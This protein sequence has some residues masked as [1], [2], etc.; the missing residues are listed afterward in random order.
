MEVKQINEFVNMALEETL[1]KSVI[2]NEDL[3]NLVSIGSE[4]INSKKVS[5]YIQNLVN[6]IGK[7]IF[8]SRV[9]EG[10]NLNIM[11]DSWEYG[12][13]VEKIRMEIPKAQPNESWE[14]K[15]GASYDTNIFYSPKIKVKFWND[16]DTFEV[17]ISITYKQL[18][19]SFSNAQQYNSF[20]SMIFTM[21]KNGMIVHLNNLERR[22]INNMIGLT[23]LSD[24]T[25]GEYS[26]KSGVKAI[27]LLYLYNK[28]KV[29]NERL[30]KETALTNPNFLRF[31][32]QVIYL[33]MD[34][35]REYSTLY[36]IE[37]CENFTKKEDMHVVLLSDFVSS[38]VA[39][40]QSD[41]YHKELVSL[42]LYEKINYWQGSGIGYTFS[43][44]SKIDVKTS[45]NTTL[46]L[47][48]IVGVLFDKDALGISNLDER[49]TDN[50]NGKA[51]FYT[52]WHKLDAGFWNDPCENFVVFFM[53]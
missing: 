30:T 10:L 5:A 36:N 28:D 20:N 12:S 19:M 8:V 37:G 21:V 35:L 13:I 40:L 32:T 17:P 29:E 18:K 42:P 9:Y 4:L 52:Y 24:Y 7:V 15:D 46:S 34:R 48:G 44:T 3:S 45:E 39:Y 14:L 43:D 38:Q 47:D 1:G 16:L 33:T 41:T 25:D 50:W 51:E 49:I 27:N 26:S 6:H 31:A 23:I 11:R 22:V 2:V 53:A